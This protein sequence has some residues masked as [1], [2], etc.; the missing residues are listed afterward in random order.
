[1]DALFTTDRVETWARAAR[2]VIDERLAGMPEEASAFW[3]AI[4]KVYGSRTA[5]VIE[6]VERLTKPMR[7]AQ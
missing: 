3:H 7:S 1:M 6:T 5:E 2:K 4:A